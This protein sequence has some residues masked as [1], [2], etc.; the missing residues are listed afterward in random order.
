MA[1]GQTKFCLQQCLDSNLITTWRH[2]PLFK[3]SSNHRLE[4]VGLNALE[5]RSF[6]MLGIER[7]W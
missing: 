6:K 3:T 1:K 7:R 4:C 5:E 2:E